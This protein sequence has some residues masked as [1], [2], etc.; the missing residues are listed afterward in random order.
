L[1]A[2]Q[3]FLEPHIMEGVELGPTGKSKLLLDKACG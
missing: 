3:A 1:N 2:I